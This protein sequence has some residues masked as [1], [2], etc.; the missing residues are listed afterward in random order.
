MNIKVN[1]Y[2]SI[3]IIIFSSFFNFVNYDEAWIFNMIENYSNQKS[4]ITFHN[5]K[6][7]ET[8][9]IKSLSKIYFKID[10]INFFLLRF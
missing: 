8:F 7:I 2:F 5:E 4:L 10:Y 3:V 9:Y 6:I 1:Y